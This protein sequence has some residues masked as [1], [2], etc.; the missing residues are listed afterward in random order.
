M[1]ATLDTQREKIEIEENTD[2]EDLM[3]GLCEA[4]D[5]LDTLIKR[6]GESTLGSLQTSL[7]IGAVTMFLHTAQKAIMKRE[8]RKPLR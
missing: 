6:L 2:E 1:I 4:R 8:G 7:N 3:C 5:A